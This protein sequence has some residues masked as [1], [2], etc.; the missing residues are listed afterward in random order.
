MGKILVWCPD[1]CRW[2]NVED[3]VSFSGWGRSKQALAGEAGSPSVGV[4]WLPG[5]R[6]LRSTGPGKLPQC[7]LLGM[8]VHFSL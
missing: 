7:R 8:E 1:G 6:A 5:P 4:R 3:T 2:G